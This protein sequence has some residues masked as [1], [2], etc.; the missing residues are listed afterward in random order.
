M[1][2][3]SNNYWINYIKVIQTSNKSWK[4]YNFDIY[5]ILLT[6]FEEGGIKDG[7]YLKQNI[8]R[9]NNDKYN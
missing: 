6:R 2:K 5:D 9:K 4:K 7:T 8:N 3:K 1:I